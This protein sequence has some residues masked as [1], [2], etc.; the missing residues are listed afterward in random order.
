MSQTS[1]SIHVVQEGELN[2][3]VWV[4]ITTAEGPGRRFALWVQGCAIRCER[5]CNP[6]MFPFS[7]RHLLSVSDVLS[8]ILK[9]QKQHHI[10]GI[11]CLGGEP[12]SQA[13]P[14]A[15]LAE[16]VQQHGLSVMV[17]SGY[18]LED[19]QAQQ[20]KEAE[21]LLSAID[22]LVD[23]PYMA[24]LHT[25][26]RR[27]IGSTNQRIHFFSDR[28]KPD[29]PAWTQPNSIDIHFDGKEL[30]ITGFPEGPWAAYFKQKR[31]AALSKVKK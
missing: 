9:S 23:G 28:Y 27:W 6:E 19:I 30:H 11:T 8:L 29:D 1:S 20:D 13:A 12:F 21:R 26:E 5:C 2:L 16:Q 22:I 25:N 3:A 15:S 24:S 7:P 14:L 18:Q 17:F 31:L 4:P 10:E